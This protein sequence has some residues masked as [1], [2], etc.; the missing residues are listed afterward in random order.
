MSL[1]YR[2][3]YGTISSLAL[4]HC[5]DS[6]MHRFMFADYSPSHPY[7]NILLTIALPT[8]P[9]W[10]RANSLEDTTT[11]P[12]PTTSACCPAARRT[13]STRTSRW[14]WRTGNCGGSSI[15]WARRWS[16]QKPDGRS[17][18]CFVRRPPGARSC[19]LAWGC[20]S[21]VPFVL[22]IFSREI[23][24]TYQ[25]IFLPSSPPL[26]TVL[27]LI[28]LIRQ[29]L[30][31]WK[32]SVLFFKLCFQLCNK[33]KGNGRLSITKHMFIKMCL[34]THVHTKLRSFSGWMFVVWVSSQWWEQITSVLSC[35]WNRMVRMV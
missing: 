14:P 5:I 22:L 10:A 2:W 23:I 15:P 30:H 26:I 4:H 13:R 18:T 27:I 21:F 32:C 9:Q 29:W 20:P 16:S 8:S 17:T 33:F 34:H 19:C 1:P 35:Q 3:I 31:F 12:P 6:S 11:S 7:L 24:L 25:Q 28:I